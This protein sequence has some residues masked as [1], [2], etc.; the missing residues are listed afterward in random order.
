MWE[1]ESKYPILYPVMP[2]DLLKEYA[3][4]VLSRPPSQNAGSMKP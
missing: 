4:K 1:G 3:E 2:N